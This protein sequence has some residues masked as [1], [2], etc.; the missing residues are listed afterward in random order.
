MWTSAQ[1]V[2]RSLHLDAVARRVVSDTLGG[3]Q[4][5]SRHPQANAM[6]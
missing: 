2:V 3:M 1:P 4:S 6:I 5:L